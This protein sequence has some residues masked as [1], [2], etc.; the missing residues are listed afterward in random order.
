MKRKK[1]VWPLDVDGVLY[2]RDDII[3]IIRRDREFMEVVK[4]AAEQANEALVKMEEAPD[5]RVDAGV[6]ESDSVR[7]PLVVGPGHD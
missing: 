5:A 3:N 6:Q 2:H 4:A 1:P 7:G